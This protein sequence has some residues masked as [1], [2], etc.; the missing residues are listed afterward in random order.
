MSVMTSVSRKKGRDLEVGR[1]RRTNQA[2]AV[3]RL[4]LGEIKN[5]EEFLRA[6]TEELETLPRCV[7]K[8]AAGDVK[9][10]VSKEVKK[11]CNQNFENMTEEKL[12]AL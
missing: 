3:G 7:L 2:G 1:I 10:I 12:K 4:M 11:F 6:D 9:K 5:W 8:H